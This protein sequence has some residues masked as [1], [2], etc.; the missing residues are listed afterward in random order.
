[1]LWEQATVCWKCGGGDQVWYPREEMARRVGSK[2]LQAVE[3]ALFW[4]ERKWKFTEKL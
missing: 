1:M 2:W 4:K 3:I